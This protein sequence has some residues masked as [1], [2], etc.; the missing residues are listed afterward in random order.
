MGFS[1]GR[2]SSSTGVCPCMEMVSLIAIMQKMEIIILRLKIK[3]WVFSELNAPQTQAIQQ[4][5]TEE[6]SMELFTR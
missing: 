1:S 6:L 2:G 5:S 4:K 3:I